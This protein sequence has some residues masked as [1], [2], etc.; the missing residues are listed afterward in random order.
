[1]KKRKLKTK[2]IVITL[3]F[4]IISIIVLNIAINN[5][6]MPKSKLQK[7]GYDNK[8][9]NKIQKLD[10]S[11]ISY[12]E[13]LDKISYIN[14]MLNNPDFKEKNLE[15]Y[16]ELTQKTNLD[17]EDVIYIINN[18]YTINKDYTK[19]I[20]NFMHQDY[21]IHKNLDRY[22]NYFDKNN[23]LDF[24]E[25][26][27]CVNANIDVP[28]YT[29]VQSVDDIENDDL[30]LVN[31]YHKLS[32]DYVPD[33]LVN[34]D[35][36]YGKPLKIKKKVLEAF[37]VMF[38]DAKKLGLSL[39]IT[40]PYR[41]YS[42]QKNLYENYAAKDGYEEADTYSARPGYSEHQ[43]GLAMDIIKSGGTLGDFETT[44]EFKWLKENA[45]KYGFILRYPKDKEYLTGYTYES[46]H[47]R[48]VGKEIAK[49]IYDNDITFEEYYAY[50]IEK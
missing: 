43:T 24:E 12:I 5:I 38:E 37:K 39:Y 34:I 42:T 2:K 28:F 32:E 29:N 44:E 50:F 1:M 21:Y 19:D 35:S 17:I 4:I 10:S 23:E 7:I 45:Y 48:Y 26:V 41:S 14:E 33:D 8:T 15:K 47:Y 13:K 16:I 27:T 40:S 11:S 3:S 18:N 22:L 31:K 25:V 9:I 49:Y 20:I 6:F 46:W 36:K 30:I